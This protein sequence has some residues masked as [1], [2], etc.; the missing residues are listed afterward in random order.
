M[1]V[2]NLIEKTGALDKTIKRH[3]ELVEESRVNLQTL[4]ISGKYK[5]VLLGVVEAIEDI[6]VI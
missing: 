1:K 4:S 3:G 5:E 6:P 2:R